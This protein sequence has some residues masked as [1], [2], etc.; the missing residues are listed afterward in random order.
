MRYG[1]RSCL[2]NEKSFFMPLHG[3]TSPKMCLNML[4]GRAM[5]QL[6]D[7]IQSTLDM[8][9]DLLRNDPEQ[10]RLARERSRAI[11]GLGLLTALQV[12]IEGRFDAIVAFVQPIFIGD[13]NGNGPFGLIQ[14]TVGTAAGGEEPGGITLAFYDAWMVMHPQNQPVRGHIWLYSA[15]STIGHDI[16]IRNTSVLHTNQREIEISRIYNGM[17]AQNHMLGLRLEQLLLQNQFDSTAFI[18]AEVEKAV[19]SLTMSAV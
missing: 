11:E 1:I 17:G 16:A 4:V 10:A 7:R 6:K 14:R 8:Q 15:L 5:G 12:A 13:A 3:V 2:M 19:V 9:L 18:I